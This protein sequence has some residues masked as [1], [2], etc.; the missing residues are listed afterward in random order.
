MRFLLSALTILSSEEIRQE[1]L[2]IPLGDNILELTGDFNHDSISSSFQY[3]PA[4]INEVILSGFFS[5]TSEDAHG[6]FS[7]NGYRLNVRRYLGQG[8][9]SIVASLPRSI[10]TLKIIL[11][12]N[13]HHEFN[14]SLQSNVALDLA[15][16]L[17]MLP[18]SV[19]FLDLTGIESLSIDEH[20]DIWKIYQAIPYTVKK[21]YPHQ[22]HW[23]L[24]TNEHRQNMFK[25]ATDKLMVF[26]LEKQKIFSSPYHAYK[27][28]FSAISSD[29]L[30]FSLAHSNIG[31]YTFDVIMQLFKSLGD[32]II[33]MNLKNNNLYILEKQ[34]Q[35]LFQ[36][37]PPK[38][39]Y[40]DISENHLLTLPTDYFKN[41][42]SFLPKKINTLKIYEQSLEPHP[43]D[44]IA[45]N[46]ASLP[47]NILV[48]G[49]AGGQWMGLKI[50]QFAW[51]LHRLSPMVFCIDYSD[52]KL[53][54]LSISDFYT[55]VTYTPPHVTKL[56]LKRNN[57]I[58]FKAN[59]LATIFSRIP[60]QVQEIDIS[61]NGFD[62]LP[63]S[64]LNEIVEGLPDIYINFGHD[65]IMHRFDGCLLPF[66][67]RTDDIY[68]KRVGLIYHQ[69]NLA[70]YFV[71]I[72]Q[73][74]KQK[75]IPE[76]LV[77][78]IISYLFPAHP[79]KLIERMVK[80][81]STYLSPKESLD[82]SDFSKKLSRRLDYQKLNETF[83][84]SHA[85]LR[86]MTS[87][88]YFRLLFKNIPSKATRIN[89]RCNGIAMQESSLS[90][91]TNSLKYLP[92]HVCY[93]DISG[94]YFE[95]LPAELARDLLVN[96][97]PWINLISLT[98]ERPVSVVNHLSRLEDVPSYFQ[99]L[100]KNE[101]NILQKLLVLLRDYTQ[102][103]SW[104][105]RLIFGY[106]NRQNIPEVRRLMFIIN[107]HQLIEFEDIM[108]YLQT[109]NMP[110]EQGALAKSMS[111]IFREHQ[112]SLPSPRDSAS[113]TPKLPH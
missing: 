105:R 2:K 87:A 32:H 111:F 33:G 50:N 46:F 4:H 71:L 58:A 35:I 72:H 21:L 73:F 14:V 48:V 22:I 45:D 34:L 6:N 15:K 52:C 112:K 82:I 55:L 51:V 10:N 84:L 43:L 93:I 27:S 5:Y 64:L 81:A 85:A 95:H 97:P 86:H 74:I 69:S 36:A 8:F 56:V 61:E 26:S 12:K 90:A 20:P 80:K 28:F 107:T 77:I 41:L 29:V 110:N 54:K 13:A 96:I 89:F 101:D 88:S 113:S 109:I 18:A 24:F 78:N 42:I 76:H 39:A 31:E 94:N 7:Y 100:I 92:K 62:R 57:L 19:D 68:F 40:L 30:G 23:S 103:D 66:P 3:L 79:R 67:W 38:I 25:A 11:K 59:E 47:P 16:S 91:F 63:M 98:L 102:D 108:H 9:A 70:D 1:F 60:Y 104:F 44:R 106:W 99:K 49:F 37:L 17:A 53:N 65:K 83:D 75:K